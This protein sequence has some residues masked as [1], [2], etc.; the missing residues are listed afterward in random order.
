MENQAINLKDVNTDDKIKKVKDNEAK[1]D[2][3]KD[4][5]KSHKSTKLD[6]KESKNETWESGIKLLRKVDV[7]VPLKLLLVCNQISDK[8]RGD[9]FSLVT[10]IKERVNDVIILDEEFYIP[11][12]KVAHTSIEYLPDDY[13]ANCVIHRHPDGMNSFS[14]TDNNYIN[15][16]FELSLLFTREGGFVAGIFNITHND[17]LI[18]VPCEVFVDNNID[19]VD[20][21]NIEREDFLLSSFSRD[22]RRKDSFKLDE[23]RSDKDIFDNSTPFKSEKLFPEET[24]DYELMRGHLLGDVEENLQNVNYRLDQIE[25]VMFH[26]PYPM[27]SGVDDLF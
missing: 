9:E 7:V 4:R 21:S 10:N 8:L 27:T 19:E 12:Q 17:Y 24:F 5:K 15:Q 23:W 18:Q 25:D 11:K 26:S 13:K 16:N 20:I 14:S 6:V 22:K 1:V 2:N 3:H